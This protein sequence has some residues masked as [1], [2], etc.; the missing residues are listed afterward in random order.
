MAC[1]GTAVGKI[2]FWTLQAAQENV[3]NPRS[4]VWNHTV[5]N[6]VVNFA[7]A[8]HSFGC[9]EPAEPLEAAT[10]RHAGGTLHRLSPWPCSLWATR[11]INPMG[12]L[13]GA[14]ADGHHGSA[15]ETSHT[16]A[17]EWRGGVTSWH[18]HPGHRHHCWTVWNIEYIFELLM[19][20]ISKGI[21][22]GM[23]MESI[24]LSCV[25]QLFELSSLFP[26][27]Y[28]GLMACLGWCW[29]FLEKNSNTYV[30]S[31]DLYCI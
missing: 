30:N 20:I 13:W 11:C 12:H 1:R 17:P 14:Q 29:V 10:G 28:L 2:T 22:V 8:K 16:T 9:H 27:R 24:W 6:L 25:M 5:D 7:C 26:V 18:P 3:G 31:D 21:W 15:A 19:Q 4:A 23:I